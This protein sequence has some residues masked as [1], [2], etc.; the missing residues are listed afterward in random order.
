MLTEGADVEYRD[1]EAGGRIVYDKVR[2]ADFDHLENND[3][4]AF[5]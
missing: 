4:L 1:S 5:N 3:W 2:L